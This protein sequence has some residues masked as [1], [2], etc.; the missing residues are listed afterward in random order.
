MTNPILPSGTTRLY[1]ILGDPVAQ[2]Q[3]PIIFNDIFR[4]WD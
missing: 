3:A 4:R 1:V 2:V